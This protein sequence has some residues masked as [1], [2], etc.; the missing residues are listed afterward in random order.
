[1]SQVFFLAL[2]NINHLYLKNTGDLSFNPIYY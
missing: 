1:M 2:D